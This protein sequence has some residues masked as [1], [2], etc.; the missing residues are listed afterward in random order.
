MNDCKITV[1][2]LKSCGISYNK[3]LLKHLKELSH[4]KTGR[5][6]SEIVWHGRGEG[7]KLTKTRLKAMKTLICFSL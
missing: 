2:P 3:Q 7:K 1:F 5:V 4:V 6:C